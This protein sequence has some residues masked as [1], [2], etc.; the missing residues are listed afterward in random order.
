MET[1]ILA[2]ACTE[3]KP[4]LSLAEEKLI[5]RLAYSSRILSQEDHDD[6]NQ[7]QVSARMPGKA[8]FFIKKA[9]IG[10]SE[11]IPDDM[12]EAYVDTSQPVLPHHPPE[13]ALHQGIYESRKDVNAII[14][15]H[16]PYA[17]VFGATDMDI[18]PISHDGAY[19]Q[20]R[21][22]RF[23]KT[24]QTI[25]NIEAGR[26][27]AEALGNGMALFLKNHGALVVGKSIREAT[28]LAILLERACKLQLMAEMLNKPYSVSSEED[29][30]GKKSFIYDDTA[31]KS[32]WDYCV[33]R[34][35][36]NGQNNWIDNE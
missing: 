21:I 27:V 14:H 12:A 13:I 6:F 25:L 16:A 7:G 26:A 11:A 1:P 33:R 10:F 2:A 5:N 30:L 24:S 18:K 22:N 20:G 19:F 3:R 29:V 31:I 32:Y 35:R 4:R 23:D 34:V 17:L 15:S 36:Q 8:T 28:V 9:I